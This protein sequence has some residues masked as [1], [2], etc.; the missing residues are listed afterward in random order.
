MFFQRTSRF[1]AAKRTAH[2]KLANLKQNTCRCIDVFRLSWLTRRSQ[3]YTTL[4]FSGVFASSKELW[5]ST[6]K[7]VNNTY[8]SYFLLH[9]YRHCYYCY[10][11]MQNVHVITQQF[12]FS[13]TLD[14]A[15]VN[16]GLYQCNFIF[17]QLLLC[18]QKFPYS[19][20]RCSF[21]VAKDSFCQ[22]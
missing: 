8:F 4:Y 18:V 17:C 12:V 10:Y 2:D 11:Y 14:N 16:C 1:H 7:P 3:I 5:I 19:V 20:P 13:L 15:I 21:D 6:F 22:V 9:L